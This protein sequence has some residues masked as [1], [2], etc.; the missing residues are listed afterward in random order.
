MKAKGS[1]AKSAAELFS[2]VTRVLLSMRFANI[3]LALVALLS[4]LSSLLPQGRELPYYAENY[5]KTYLLI[6]RTHFY[7]VFKSWYFVLLMAL[8]CLSLL[9]CTARMLRRAL[10]GGRR[11]VEQAATLPNAEPLGPGG[12]EALRRYGASIRCKE[13]KIGE[14]FV[15]HKNEIGRWGVFL[16]HLSILLIVGF[17]VCAL[18][19]PKVSDV[20][21]YPGES[22]VMA[23]GTEIFVDSF[24]MN[25]PEGKL[26][27]ASVIR[28][29]LPDGRES[30]A[31]EIKVNY[32]LTFGNCKVFQWEYGV[33]GDVVVR[34][35]SG[36]EERYHL[37]K[38]SYLTDD[39]ASGI[40]Y[41]Q[42]VLLQLLDYTEAE[43]VLRYQIRVIDHGMVMPKASY[44]AV[45]ESVEVGGFTYSFRDPY[46][47]GLR[48]KQMPFPYANSL[49]EAA[50]VLMLLGLFLCFYLRPVLIK[51]DE[52]GYTVAGPR[53]ERVR[54]EIRQ[55]L[56]REEGSER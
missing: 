36:G 56:Q 43:P 24:T 32:P 40:L 49:L 37:D 54:M 21:C 19:L 34:D 31:Q 6:Y 44:L 1:F 4:G 5:P 15:L 48:V 52:Q 18:Y 7:D 9:I 53:P 16:L 50:F 39:D 47:P 26:D 25:D 8:L 23:D 11:A 38:A 55:A 17:G 13:E 33:A 46:Y 27:Y 41:E 30:A 28:V 35:G 12:L 45:G 22:V 2:P 3:L 51:V 29:R 42:V 20:D 10:R 14:A